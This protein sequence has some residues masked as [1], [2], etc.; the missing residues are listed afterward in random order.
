MQVLKGYNFVIAKPWT[1]GEPALMGY[2]FGGV[3]QFG[4]DEMAK[5]HRDFIRERAKDE[6]Y[7]IFKVY[8]EPHKL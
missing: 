7:E 2:Y 1:N 8:S 5:S 4:D 6:S 3:I